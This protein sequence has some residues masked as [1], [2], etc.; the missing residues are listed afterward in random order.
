MVGDDPR[1][2]VGRRVYAKAIHVT[3]LAECARRFGSRSKTKEVAGT[4][5]ECIDRKTK[6]NRQSTYVKAVYALGGGT[7][8]TVELNIR[9]VLKEV[10]DP[11]DSVPEIR[12]EPGE[13]LAAQIPPRTQLE[14]ANDDESVVN[15]LPNLPIPDIITIQAVVPEEPAEIAAPEIAAPEVATPEVAAHEVVA[16]RDTDTEVSQV[17]NRLGE[18]TVEVHDTKWYTDDLISSLHINGAIPTRDF[19]IRTPVGEMLTRNSDRAKKYSRFDYLRFMFPPDEIDLIVRLTNI[20]LE[21]HQV[22]ATTIGGIIQF[23]GVWILSTRFEF[24]SRSSLW[25]NTAPSKYVPAPAFGKT[26]LSRHRFDTLWRHIRFSEQDDKRPEGMSSE[27]FRWKLVDD[28][29][30]NFNLHRATMFVPGDSICVDESISRWYGLGG[31]W[32]NIGLPMYIAIERKPDNGCEIQDAACGRSKI[33]IRLKLVKTSTEE[34]ADSIAEDDQGH[35]HGTKVLLNLILPWANS[36]RVVCADS[37]FAS[38]GAAET[39]KRIGLRFIGVVKTATKRFPMKHLS[40]IELVNRGD[41]RGLI[42]YDNDSK[43]SLLAFCWMDRDRR[44]FIASGSSLSPGIPHVRQRWRQLN[45]EDPNADPERVELEVPQPKACELYYNTCAA[46]DNH[47]RYRQSS[48][49]LEKKLGTKDWAMRINM[50]LF[51]I[52]IVDTWLAYKLCTGTEETQAAFY[53]ALAEEMIDNTYDTPNQTRSQNNGYESPNESL[54]DHATGAARSGINAHLTPTKKKRKLKNGML[55]NHAKQG[56]CHECG[57][58]TRWNCSKCIDE[59]EY[60]DDRDIWLCHTETGRNCF[61]D[62]MEVNH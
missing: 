9:S 3:S 14:D 11:Q 18:P 8:K 55:T 58:K 36:D 49:M 19:G 34:A 16:D 33:M 24:G 31:E 45:T 1:R 38:V 57:R 21:K 47:N 25:S 22:K 10:R 46:V 54:F 39:L 40:Q 7:L 59:K 37:Y 62:H 29:V 20:Q 61:T 42:M 41:R 15:L 12:Q 48:L 30:T 27:S 6:T 2:I 26:G 53:L 17:I 52:C 23:F 4:V 51:A 32:I 43:P 56:Y 28:F 35:L 44:Y 50:S 13:P 5:L 60:P